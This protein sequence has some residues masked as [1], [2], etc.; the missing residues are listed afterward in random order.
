MKKE[1]IDI[2]SLAHPKWHCKQHIVFA[3]K[4]GRRCFGKNSKKYEKY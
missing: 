2:N 3:P 1:N 4:Y